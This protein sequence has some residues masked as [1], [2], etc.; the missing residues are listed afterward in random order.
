MFFSSAPAR[1]RQWA[2]ARRDAHR[3]PK[4]VQPGISHRARTY[5][6]RP[7]RTNKVR[8]RHIR[9]VRATPR[10]VTQERAL[11]GRYHDC[12]RGELHGLSGW[13]D[14][15]RADRACRQQ[16]QER[17]SQ[18]GGC[19][20]D[21]VV[22]IDF[23]VQCI[24]DVCSRLL[25]FGWGDDNGERAQHPGAYCGHGRT[26]RTSSDPVTDRRVAE[27]MSEVPRIDWRARSE[28]QKRRTEQPTSMFGLD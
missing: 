8:W 24:K 17:V 19:P 1:L 23:L 5:M 3:E 6:P 16:W 11:L 7:E 27:V 12:G 26:R 15:G 14:D 21:L 2:W 20:A 25:N 13:L 18:L 9:R 28:P 10:Q 4:G 22:D